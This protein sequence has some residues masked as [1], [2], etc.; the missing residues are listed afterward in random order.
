MLGVGVYMGFK[1]FVFV[2]MDYLSSKPRNGHFYEF[3]VRKKQLK[4]MIM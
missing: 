4:L 3:G 2:G 1:E